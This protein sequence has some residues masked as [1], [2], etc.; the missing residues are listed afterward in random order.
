MGVVYSGLTHCCSQVSVRKEGGV[1]GVPL[2][3][4]FLLF[5][6]YHEA[7]SF[8]DAPT[9]EPADHELKPL[10]SEARINLSSLILYMLSQ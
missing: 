6:S 7:S 8:H 2:S 9:M 5:L 1:T 3:A 4:P 10:K